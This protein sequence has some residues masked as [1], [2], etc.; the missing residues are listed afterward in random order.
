MG[1]SSRGWVPRFVWRFGVKMNKRI[2]AQEQTSELDQLTEQ[3]RM[4]DPISEIAKHIADFY[5]RLLPTGWVFEDVLGAVG[6]VLQGQVAD[7]SLVDDPEFLNSV[8][9]AMQRRTV[10]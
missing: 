5:F 6:E 9:L 8:M 2:Y 3:D 10:H 7:V 4:V 1:W